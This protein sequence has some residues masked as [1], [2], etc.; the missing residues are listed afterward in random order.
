VAV[1][2]WRQLLS[3]DDGYE[4][5][6]GAAAGEIAAVEA[7]LE[8]VFPADLRQVYLASDGVFDRPGQWFVIWPLSEIV[9]RNREAW[10]HGG[11]PGRRE[12]VGFGDDGTG[13]PFCVPRDGGGGVFAWS[14]IDGEAT[15]LAGSVARFWSGWVTGTLP[16]H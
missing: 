7:A 2:D 13:T 4:Q 10:S 5:C 11:S 9:T 16:P 14:A 1:I 15:L 12:L 3:A 6:P 8:A